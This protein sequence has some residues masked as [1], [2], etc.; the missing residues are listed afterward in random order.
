MKIA[1][2]LKRIRTEDGMKI[3]DPLKRI[4]TPKG[5]RPLIR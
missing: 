4:S 3:A 5:P 1:D 2:P